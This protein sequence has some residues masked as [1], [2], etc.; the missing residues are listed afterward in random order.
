M[1]P[2]AIPSTWRYLQSRYR[3]VASHCA[4]GIVSFPP[5]NYCPECKQPIKKRSPLSGKGIL[6]SWTV[7]HNPPEG[8]ETEVPYILGLIKLNEGPRIT[9]QLVGITPKEIFP[10]MKVKMAFRRLGSSPDEETVLQYGYKFIPEEDPR[11]R[12]I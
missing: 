6:E 5:W 9:A 7:V 11:P 1:S 2:I 8:W 3:L 10:G 12:E 4:C